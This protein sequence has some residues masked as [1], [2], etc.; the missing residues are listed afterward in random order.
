MQ[1]LHIHR[2]TIAKGPHDVGSTRAH[3]VPKFYRSMTATKILQA[4]HRHCKCLH[5]AGTIA[6]RHLPTPT[7]RSSIAFTALYC[8]IAQTLQMPAPGWHHTRT[9]SPPHP[10][11]CDACDFQEKSFYLR[12]RLSA[13]AAA[14]AAIIAAAACR[15]RRIAF[16]SHE[17]EN[18]PQRSCRHRVGT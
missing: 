3:I 11:P 8:F 4:S 13:V 15:P 9:T 5:Q 16:S 18:P 10:Q 12:A 6:A 2:E 7:L 17:M 1:T 14:A